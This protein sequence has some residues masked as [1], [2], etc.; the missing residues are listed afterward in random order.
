MDSS[1][2]NLFRCATTKV[3]EMEEEEVKAGQYQCH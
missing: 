2:L 3:N 1:A